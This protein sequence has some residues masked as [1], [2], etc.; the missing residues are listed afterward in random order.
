MKVLFVTEG[1]SGDVISTRT[2]PILSPYVLSLEGFPFLGDVLNRSILNRRIS[3]AA[4]VVELA[5]TIVK[6]AS[7]F[8]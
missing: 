4:L 7:R 8:L 2:S 5:T 6:R 3:R 1:A